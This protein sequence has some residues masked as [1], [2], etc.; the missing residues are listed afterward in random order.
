MRWALKELKVP[1]PPEQRIFKK[2]KINFNNKF[3]NL[4]NKSVYYWYPYKK[5]N[6][7]EVE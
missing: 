6:I 5:D 2:L 7:K 1:V 4:E 3:P